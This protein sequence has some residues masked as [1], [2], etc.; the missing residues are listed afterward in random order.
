ML[1]NEYKKN[2]IEFY[3]NYSTGYQAGYR[4]SGLR[5]PACQKMNLIPEVKRSHIRLDTGYPA[6][7]NCDNRPDTG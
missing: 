5:Y 1:Y 3:I 6:V 2:K 7:A 4:L